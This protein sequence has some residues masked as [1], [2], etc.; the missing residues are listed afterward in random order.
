MCGVGGCTNKRA[1]LYNYSG[2]GEKK[3][4]SLVRTVKSNSQLH[5]DTFTLKRIG[6]V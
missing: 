3:K 4:K 6:E 1:D 2:S 5:Y